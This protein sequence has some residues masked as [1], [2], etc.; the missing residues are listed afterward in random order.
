LRL[1][2]SQSPADAIPLRFTVRYLRRATFNRTNGSATGTSIQL[3]VYRTG[4]EL[5]RMFLPP[6]IKYCLISRSG[7]RLE[8]PVS[9]AALLF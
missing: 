7:A 2:C 5:L 1:L 8:L 3:P 6:A 4:R 9:P